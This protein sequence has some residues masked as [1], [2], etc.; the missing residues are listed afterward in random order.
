MPEHNNITKEQAQ[1][2]MVQ[3]VAINKAIESETNSR[4]RELHLLANFFGCQIAKAKTEN[5]MLAL[6]G[7]YTG[8]SSF[9]NYHLTKNP[10]ARK[11]Y[12]G[13]MLF[14]GIGTSTAGCAI[15]SRAVNISKPAIVGDVLG[16]YFMMLGNRSHVLAL[17]LE[18][19]PIPA[20]LQRLKWVNYNKLAFI[21]FGHYPT[22]YFD[23]IINKVT[24][25]RL[26]RIVSVGL[27]FYSLSY[28]GLLV[29]RSTK[30][31]YKTTKT[32]AFDKLD[33]RKRKTQRNKRIK[34]EVAFRV[35]LKTL[36]RVKEKK[37]NTTP[38]FGRSSKE[39][40]LEPYRLGF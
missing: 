10:A 32:L 7:L 19:K 27:T 37:P 12:A 33:E 2:L 20:H 23:Q 4:D 3:L 26:D 17:Q 22:G 6:A 38:L 25:Q 29:C 16:A 11:L 30:K 14:S 9:Q 36:N 40:E 34:S 1:Y 28:L 15:V 39:Y 8:G 24:Y 31:L 35:F 5:G 21:R 13:S 18:N